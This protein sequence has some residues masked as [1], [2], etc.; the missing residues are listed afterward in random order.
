MEHTEKYPPPTTYTVKYEPHLG[1]IKEHKYWHLPENWRDMHE[2]AEEI[3]Q[4]APC[5]VDLYSIKVDERHFEYLKQKLNME[6]IPGS[7]WEYS[8]YIELLQGNIDITKT[9]NDMYHLW[10]WSEHD[11]DRDLWCANE[12][13]Y[14][15]LF[16][17]DNLC[18]RG[19][20]MAL[21]PNW[22][23]TFN[24]TSLKM[25]AGIIY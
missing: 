17:R 16:K 19:L 9:Q 5:Y 24:E 20:H 6:L 12:M 23:G 3:L 2:M 1:P 8:F 21:D 22:G 11:K 10:L 14:N 25:A 7:E 13:L 15:K 18:R 4:Q